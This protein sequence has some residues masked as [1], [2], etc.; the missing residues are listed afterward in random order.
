MRGY[1]LRC[2]AAFIPTKAGIHANILCR[3]GLGME[4]PV[5]T[6]SSSCACPPR[7]APPSFV[8]DGAGLEVGGLEPFA[9]F[10]LLAVRWLDARD[11]EAAVGADDRK[12]VCLHRHDL[13]ELA[14]DA[15]WGLCRERLGVEDLE[16]LAGELGPGT[17]RRIA[18][19]DQAIDLLPG[20]APV[21][22]GVVRTAAAL[23]GRLRLVL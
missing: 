21:Y 9:G 6:L 18:A 3:V 15:L 19:A 8:E 1:S 7:R 16:L 22:P 12:A 11:L 5:V 4:L 23:V 13:A 14:A 17:G 10:D 20:L 2:A